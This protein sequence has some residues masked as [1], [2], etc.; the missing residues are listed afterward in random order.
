MNTALH[1]SSA[2]DK[3]ATP[4]SFFDKVNESYRFTLD[5]CALPESAKCERYFTPETDGLGQM[6]APEVCWMNPPYGRQI[7]R[8]VQKAYRESRRGATVVCL[9]PARTDTTW[10]HD[11]CLHGEVE[12]LKGR[13]KFG[14]AKNSAPFPSM[15]VTFRPPV[16]FQGEDL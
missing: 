1:F 8:W 14:G 7:G 4:Q 16:L 2:N 5:V 9:L 3:W 15:L 10:F 11:Y 6:W 12:F 13:L